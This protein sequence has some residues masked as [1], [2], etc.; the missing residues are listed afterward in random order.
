MKS[1]V[2]LF[3]VACVLS[4]SGCGVRDDGLPKYSVRATVETVGSASDKATF[5]L[6]R[7]TESSELF[8]PEVSAQTKRALTLHG[9]FENEDKPDYE[10]RVKYGIGDPERNFES[11]PAII[12]GVIGNVI[13]GSPAGS[14]SYTTYSPHIVLIGFDPKRETTAADGTKSN[15]AIW[16]T[17]SE[18]VANGDLRRYLP[19]L[20]TAA[21]EHIGVDTQVMRG[22][23]VYTR[24]KEA[25][26]IRG[27]VPKVTWMRGN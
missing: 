21:I 5:K 17:A 15:T 22:V 10:I 9:W 16:V 2:V 27:Y 23:R 4:L 24:N 14:S 3:V 25:L 18:C 11:H 1:T 8:W 26:T 13:V 7:D 20:L 19:Y 6:V 12:Y